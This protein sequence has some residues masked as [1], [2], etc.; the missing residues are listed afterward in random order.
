MDDADPNASDINSSVNYNN[1]DQLKIDFLAIPDSIRTRDSSKYRAAESSKGGLCDFDFTPFESDRITMTSMLLLHL[2]PRLQSLNIKE[3]DRRE[4]LI[5]TLVSIPHDK[6]PAGL[7]S[8][9]EFNYQGYGVTSAFL[10]TLLRLPCIRSVNVYISDTDDYERITHSNTSTGPSW[11]PIYGKSNVINLTIEDF[12][13]VCPAMSRILKIPRALETIGYV[14]SCTAG[15]LRDL[16]RVLRLL[17]TTLQALYLT[18]VVSEMDGRVSATIGTLRGWPVLHAVTTSLRI[19][20]G[21]PPSIVRLKDVLPAGIREL[22]IVS[23]RSWS[24]EATVDVFLG[25]LSRKH[26]VLN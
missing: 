16:G 4:A 13:F 9:H 2:L 22:K 10:Y 20:M 26:K 25:L 17:Q 3:L 15:E 1:L 11:P 5:D 18:C 6:L 24:M 8:I 23:D 14:T 7:L 21:R 12:G 19:L